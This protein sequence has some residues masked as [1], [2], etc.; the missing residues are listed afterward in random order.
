MDCI[1]FNRCYY[2]SG[3][4]YYV[5]WCPM[6]INRKVVPELLRRAL[7]KCSRMYENGIYA[8][9]TPVEYLL[10]S[11]YFGHYDTAQSTYYNTKIN[12][13]ISRNFTNYFRVTKDIDLRCFPISKY[14]M[15]NVKL[16]GG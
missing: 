6:T 10:L 13:G 5:I 7:K 16:Y 8:Y 2:G 15:L 12:R 1:L 11:D 3:I 4:G 9:C 14:A